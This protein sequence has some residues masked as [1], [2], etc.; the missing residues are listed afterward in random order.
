MPGIT[1]LPS[2]GC[3]LLRTLRNLL[4][5]GLYSILQGPRQKEEFC[6][7]CHRRRDELLGPSIPELHL[8]L[9]VAASL[10]NSH[11]PLATISALILS[12]AHGNEPCHLGQQSKQLCS[13]LA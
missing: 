2:I 3:N 12:G 9:S 7:G 4:F 13:Q 10:I 6:P 1:Y 11:W 5:C 8:S